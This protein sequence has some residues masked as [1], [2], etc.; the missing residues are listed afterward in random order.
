[1][2]VCSRGQHRR[3]RY[4]ASA[5]VWPFLAGDVGA[6]GGEANDAVDWQRFR[7]EC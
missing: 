2:K 4:T 1:M 7:Q 6:Q 5:R 3:E